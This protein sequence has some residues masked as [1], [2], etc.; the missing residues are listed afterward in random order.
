MKAR[1]GGGIELVGSVP[2]GALSRIR[3]ALTFRNLAAVHDPTAPRW[4]TMVD[5]LIDRVIVPRG[6]A[7]V[8]RSALPG[9]EFDDQ[10]VNGEPVSVR[11]A[12]D[13][14]GYQA[15]ARDALVRKVQGSIVVPCGGGKTVIALGSIAKVGRS[16]L[17]LVHTKD[18]LDQW[19]GSVAQQLAVSAG[20]IGD[21]VREVKP[22]TIAMVQTLARWSIV[23]LRRLGRDFGVVVV[24]EAHHIPASTFRGLMPHLPGRWRFGLTATPER[25]D[26]L[27]PML[28]AAIGPVVDTVSIA[29]LVAAGRLVWPRIY[30]VE[31]GR[32]YSATKHTGLLSE[33]EVDDWR[34]A[35]IVKTA[36]ALA[37]T[38]RRVLV[39]SLR[40]A[41][42]YALQEELRARG[43]KASA[44]TG[45]TKDRKG[46]LDS[47]RGG[48]LDVVI[49]TTLADEA[50]DVPAA[51]SLVLTMP[52]RSPGRTIQRVGRVIR[53]NAGKRTPLVFDFVDR[54]KT[55]RS[56][57]YKRRSAYKKAYGLDVLR[58]IDLGRLL[59]MGD[60]WIA[61]SSPE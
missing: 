55:A 38:G 19:C 56:Q 24:D 47:F 34:N 6:A 1:V 50:L 9:I 22:I 46:V 3:D 51:D 10:R 16:A 45:K 26:G 49:A 25:S 54:H 23:E 28:H 21:G 31:T 44:L 59:R 7:G 48:S 58:K 18:L 2:G 39:L 57:W 60:A 11:H 32:K 14:H 61:Q 12:F 27:E 43:V 35:A 20:A 37:V 8:V 42:C 13:L 40:V 52:Q 4:I 15:R 41:H 5:E 30:Q 36:H 29:E 17:V 53:S 33:I